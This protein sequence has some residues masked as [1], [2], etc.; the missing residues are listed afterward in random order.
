[1]LDTLKSVGSRLAHTI[2][3]VLQNQALS[4]RKASVFEH[5]SA[6]DTIVTDKY[7]EGH[8]FVHAKLNLSGTKGF[9]TYTKHQGG[10]EV[11]KTPQV[12][13][14]RQMLQT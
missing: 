13:Q 14:E 11:E 10:G 3:T 12:S 2:F 5:S 8:S 7:S 6:C 9:G 4:P 1:M